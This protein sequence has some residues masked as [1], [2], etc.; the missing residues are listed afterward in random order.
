MKFRN[1][2]DV[3]ILLAVML[4]RS[5][6]NRVRV[7]KKSVAELRCG[8][9]RPVFFV[10]LQN[11]CADLGVTLV[12]LTTGGYAMIVTSSLN[13]AKVQI[14]N[15]HYSP[16]ELAKPDFDVLFAEL[17]IEEPDYGDEA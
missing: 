9:I 5:G 4:K 14:P 6:I 11:E 1:A 12:E 13:G 15:K 8:R 10:E 16:E 2:R 17:E 7:S 3:A